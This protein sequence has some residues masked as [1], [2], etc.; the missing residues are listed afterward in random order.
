MIL[1]KFFNLA[2]IQLHLTPEMPG[3]LR[4]YITPMKKKK[5]GN[6][7]NFFPWD[8]LLVLETEIFKGTGVFHVK[9]R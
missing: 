7:L 5:G 9:Y 2:S 4:Q 6:I 3:L 1:Y 8:H